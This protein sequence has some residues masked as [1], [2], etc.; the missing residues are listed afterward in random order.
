MNSTNGVISR[1]TSSTG[2]SSVSVKYYFTL[3]NNFYVSFK[4]KKMSRFRSFE[5]NER[6]RTHKVTKAEW[7]V[8]LIVVSMVLNRWRLSTSKNEMRRKNYEF[9][10]T[11]HGVSC[12]VCSSFGII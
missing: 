4:V 7:N 12:L 10:I 6:K 11:Q 3:K 5:K 9:S 1:R 2:S 8:S